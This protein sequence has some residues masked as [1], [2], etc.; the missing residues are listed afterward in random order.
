MSA[1][2]PKKQNT[3]LEYS[4]HTKA[5]IE[6]NSVWLKKYGIPVYCAVLYNGYFS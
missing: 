5:G 6:K 3:T 4:S 1:D 2:F